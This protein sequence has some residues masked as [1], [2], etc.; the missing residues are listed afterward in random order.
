MSDEKDAW[1]IEDQRGVNWPAG[2][3]PVIE[4]YQPDEDPVP[5]NP[6]RGKGTIDREPDED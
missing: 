2:S 1:E 4:G 5:V 3:D 6:P